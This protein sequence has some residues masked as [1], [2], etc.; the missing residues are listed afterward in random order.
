[1]NKTELLAGTRAAFREKRSTDWPVHHVEVIDGDVRD[2]QVKVLFVEGEREGLRSWVRAEQLLCRWNEHEALLQDERHEK[3]LLTDWKQRQDPVLRTA[4]S[5]V[6]VATGESGGV[7]KGWDE[8][9][10]VFD[11]LW[12]RAGLEKRP[13]DHA[14]AYRDRRGRLHLP[15][16]TTLEFCVAF[17]RAEPEMV[18][19]LIDGYEREARAKGFLPGNSY[20]HQ[21]LR[22]DVAAHAVVRDWCGNEQERDRL[23]KEIER[24]QTLVATAALELDRAG[25]TGAGNRLRRA[26]R[27]L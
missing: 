15:W 2:R 8:Q 4:M 1:M 11:R 21:W 19:T 17:C 3:A 20:H 18:L 23:L 12:K 22:E 5:A 6:L 9:P 13:N 14:L 16:D 24:L 7:D 26:A 10:A 25:A 27:G